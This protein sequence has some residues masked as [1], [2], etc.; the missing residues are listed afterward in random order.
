MSPTYQSSIGLVHTGKQIRAVAIH[1]D[2]D[3]SE[4]AESE[5]FTIEVAPPTF[6]PT[7]GT[8]NTAKEITRRVKEMKESGQTRWGKKKTKQAKVADGEFG[9]VGSQGWLLG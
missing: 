5:A 3:N 1:P 8:F 9:V 4:V 7:G 6:E 2:M